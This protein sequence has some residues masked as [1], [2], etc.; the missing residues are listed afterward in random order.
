MN[1]NLFEEVINNK[2]TNF[3]QRKA[4]KTMLQYVEDI[5]KELIENE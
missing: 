2:N 1:R 3:I 4:N 5:E